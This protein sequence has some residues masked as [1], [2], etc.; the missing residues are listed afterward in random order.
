MSFG[1]V[2]IKFARPSSHSKH[3]TGRCNS[4]MR[5]KIRKWDAAGRG[6]PRDIA[7]WEEDGAISAISR[8]AGHLAIW[9]AG[10]LDAPFCMPV[11]MLSVEKCQA[12]PN[13]NPIITDPLQACYGHA[14]AYYGM[15]RPRENN[16]LNEHM[17][18]TCRHSRTAMR[19]SK[20]RSMCACRCW[21]RHRCSPAGQS[22]PA[23]EA[24]HQRFSPSN[25]RLRSLGLLLIIAYSRI[26]HLHTFLSHGIVLFG[27]Y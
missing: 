19:R 2:C 8:R 23:P 14:R 26:D 5:L 15:L 27:Y 24:W 1:V 16:C 25:H 7:L 4:T 21:K 17:S 13:N 9:L 18:A 20:R 11:L 12:G 3:S 22:A 10:V 6:P